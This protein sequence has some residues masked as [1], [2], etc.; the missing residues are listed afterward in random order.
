MTAVGGALTSGDTAV[1]KLSRLPQRLGP[2]V[3]KLKQAPRDEASRSKMRDATQPWRAWYRSPRWR[4]LRPKILQR[5][6]YLCRQTG[7]LLVGKYPAEDSPVVDHIRPHHGDPVL[8]W[9][10]DNLQSGAKGWHDS[11]KQSLERRGLA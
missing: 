10:E 4:A 7:V 11:V 1:A 6:L 8:F 3:A 5:D 2:A 9:D